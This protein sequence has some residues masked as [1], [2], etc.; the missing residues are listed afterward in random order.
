MNKNSLLIAALITA[1]VIYLTA[2]T[3]PQPTQH[4][5]TTTPE[6]VA[7]TAAR[8]EQAAANLEATATAYKTALATLKAH[9]IQAPTTAPAQVAARTETAPQ[10]ATA[11]AQVCPTTYTPQRGAQA[12]QA[13]E[14]H[15]GSRGGCWY[16]NGS[17]N[18]T[19]LP[20]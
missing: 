17:G 10:A 16:L 14:V 9:G 6:Q 4:Q 3:A 7:A 20:K 12:G 8:L 5:Q 19:Y 1:A 13:Q 18:K 11:A 2:C 15:T